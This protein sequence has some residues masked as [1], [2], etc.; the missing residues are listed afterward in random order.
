MLIFCN[1]TT[2]SKCAVWSYLT[3]FPFLPVGNCAG[4]KSKSLASYNRLTFP[5]PYLL[6]LQVVRESLSRRP[7]SR[8]CSQRML[9]PFTFLCD[10]EESCY[11]YILEHLRCRI[12]RH[13]FFLWLLSCCCMSLPILLSFMLADLQL[14]TPPPPPPAGITT[15]FA[16]YKGLHYCA[17]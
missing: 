11:V 4:C 9:G 5:L 8:R 6:W 16:T 14:S 3:Y 7:R 15:L 1:V 13:I 17:Y 12:E 2:K 10:F